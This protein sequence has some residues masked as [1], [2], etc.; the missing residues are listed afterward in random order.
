MTV[1]LKHRTIV[2]TGAAR[3]IGAG[4][5]KA[6]AAE[7][8]SLVVADL[9]LDEAEGVASQIRDDGGRAVAVEVDVTE[10]DQVAAIIERAVEEFGQLDAYFNNAGINAPMNLLEVT[11]DNWDSIL[12][13]NAFG[14]LVGIQEAAKQFLAQATSGKIV[15]TAS[16][17]GRQG[18]AAIAPYCASKAA[19]I[20]LTQS[21]ARELAPHGITVNGF[22]PGVVETPL[23]ND[24]DASLEAMGKPEL[25]FDGMSEDILL[26]RPALP[27]DIAPTAVFLAAPDSDYITGQIIP[28]EGGMILV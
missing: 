23:W 9:N 7:G 21:A 28:I 2:V 16:I 22:A 19:V 13:V 18:Y 14:V 25:K 20:T 8:A 4:I 11:R 24:L 17:A 1:R 26:G 3:G 12:T 10:R 15:N 6:M 5:A 27:D